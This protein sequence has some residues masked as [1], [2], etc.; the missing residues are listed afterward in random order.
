MIIVFIRHSKAIPVIGL[1]TTQWPLTDIGKDLARKLAEYE[2]I[3]SLTRIITSTQVKAVQT[4]EIIS[5]GTIRIDL[6]PGLAGILG[7]ETGILEN[8]QELITR[9]LSGKVTRI[10]GGETIDE[11]R[12]RIN[13]IIEKISCNID[14]TEKVGIVTHGNI[15]ALLVSQYCNLSALEL[16]NVIG[17]PDF[18][19]IDWTTKTL[20]D[21]FGKTFI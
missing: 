9:Y 10:N 3:R 7:E 16:H 6:E 17:M 8:Y 21:S 2:E 20:I 5:K 18:I 1:P 15:L 19:T 14:D 11:A 12:Y 13:S 4:A